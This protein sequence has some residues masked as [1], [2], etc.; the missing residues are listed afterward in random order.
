[1]KPSVSP[2]ETGGPFGTLTELIVDSYAETAGCTASAL[3]EKRGPR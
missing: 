2:K 1:V 3:K